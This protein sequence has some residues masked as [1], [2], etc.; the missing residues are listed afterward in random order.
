ML[1]RP[2]V[3]EATAP[4]QV[5]VVGPMDL[6][7]IQSV[8][9]EAQVMGPVKAVAQVQAEEVKESVEQLAVADQAA[10]VV[11]HQAEE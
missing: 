1:G 3:E 7:L 2:Q 8:A 9:A 5:Q 11:D 6:V 4:L 10:V